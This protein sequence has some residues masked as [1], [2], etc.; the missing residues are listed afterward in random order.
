MPV[1]QRGPSTSTVSYGKFIAGLVRDTNGRALS[2]SH[3]SV[4]AYLVP[5]A[6]PPSHKTV[7]PSTVL[8]A[9]LRGMRGLPH[10]SFGRS[11]APPRPERSSV[12][13]GSFIRALLDVSCKSAS[14]AGLPG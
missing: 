5:R 14:V 2:F 10:D 12:R 6:V 13:E 8:M 3:L 4:A 1:S 11:R 7:G 9:Y